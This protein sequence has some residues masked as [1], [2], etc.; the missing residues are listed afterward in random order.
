MKRRSTLLLAKLS[1]I[2]LGALLLAGPAASHDDLDAFWWA[3]DPIEGLWNVKVTI[4]DCRGNPLPMPPPFDALALF[5]RGGTFHDT[6]A[7]NPAM[8]SSAFGEWKRVKPRTYEFAFKVFRFNA[9]TP[10]GSQIVRHTVVLA[11]DGR[12]YKSFGTSEVFDVAGT[13]VGN[14]CSSSVATPFN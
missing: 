5:A 8:R 9:G 3:P 7:T 13:L 4:E 10:L 14:G 6:N 12:S 1:T 2:A 11:R